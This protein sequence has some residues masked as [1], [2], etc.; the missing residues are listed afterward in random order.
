LGSEEN[1]QPGTWR[2]ALQ[3]S[4]N[5]PWSLLGSALGLGAVAALATFIP[6]RRAAT[7]DPIAALRNE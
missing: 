4:A 7:V 2:A 5:D 3:V 1:S 6:A